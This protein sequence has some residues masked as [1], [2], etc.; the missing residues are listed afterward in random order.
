[1]NKEFE[2]A[3]IKKMFELAYNQ[4]I[5]RNYIKPYYQY[6]VKTLYK[7]M[8]FGVVAVYSKSL[9]SYVEMYKNGITVKIK[10][11][12]IGLYIEVFI[13]EK[14][15]FDKYIRISSID[16]NANNFYIKDFLKGLH[17]LTGFV[18]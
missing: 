12:N 13:N 3:Y 7:Q 2:I 11:E 17:N 8:S 16:K 5:L 9:Y 1:M 6:L 10:E 15:I 18:G 14:Y 4:R